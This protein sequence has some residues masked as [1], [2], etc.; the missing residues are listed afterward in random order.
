[1][2]GGGGADRPGQETKKKSWGPGGAEL[3]D[4]I[5]G[6]GT[7]KKHLWKGRPRGFTFL[8]VK[9]RSPGT[10]AQGGGLDKREDFHV[11]QG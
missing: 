8:E 6:F 5:L 7:P 3:V 2:G 10:A 11:L 9:K 1:M 4:G